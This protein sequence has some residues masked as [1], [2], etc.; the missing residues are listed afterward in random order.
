FMQR[1]ADPE[2]HRSFLLAETMAG[3]D[4]LARVGERHIIQ[5]LHRA[6]FVDLDLRGG[7]AVLP[8]RCGIA[9][10]GVVAALDL[11]APAPRDLAFEIAEV[12]PQNLRERSLFAAA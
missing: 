3:I 2:E 9:E 1:V 12:A 10:R 4:H 5:K 7:E 6:G 11:V 8:K